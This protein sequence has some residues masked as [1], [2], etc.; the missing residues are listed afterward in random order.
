VPTIFSG[1][2]QGSFSEA[3]ILLEAHHTLISHTPES[4]IFFEIYGPGKAL[5]FPGFHYT[6]DGG[7]LTQFPLPYTAYLA[8]FYGIFGITGFVLANAI[9]LFVTTVTLSTIA[10]VFVD[11]R[12]TMIFL[13]LFIT[14]F[15]IG[16]FA[17]F[18][19]SENFASALLWSVVGLYF[20][21]RDRITPLTYYT[22]LITL[23]LLLFARIES[24]W[25]FA[26]MIVLI[27][28]EKKI[29]TFIGQAPWERLVLPV[30]T[31]F[32]IALTVAIMNQPFLFTIAKALLN[33]F[34][35]AND[36]T[37]MTLFDKLL[38][39]LNI[40][41]LYGLIGPLFITIAG[42]IWTLFHRSHRA[43]LLPI[44][45][46]LPFFI[47]YISPQITADHPWMLRRFVF[48]VLPATI[49]FSVIFLYHFAHKKIARTIVVYTLFVILLI[50][51]LPAFVKFVTYAENESLAD[52]VHFI[53]E[54]FS[55][56]DLILVDKDVAGNGWTMIT[57]PLRNIENIPAVY[58]FNPH[59][60]S[61]LNTESFETVYLITPYENRDRYMDV[62]GDQMHYVR[63]YALTVDH[64]ELVHDRSI[65]QKIPTHSTQVIRGIIYEIT[66]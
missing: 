20:M 14:S 28:R 26:I 19:L 64:L 61:S 22:F 39:Y 66:P 30:T 65:P 35:S 44:V 5:N 33:V 63:K 41:A 25:L 62:F 7:L 13:A 53:A 21:M 40:Y 16:W 45:I 49:L 4:D 52:Q 18:T 17:K 2:D 50:N 24:I 51:N 56:N 23:S 43:I 9:L 48:A 31:L 6:P 3:A 37:S 15:A 38:Y 27:L 12:G 47:Y 55:G 54:D 34:P 42:V 8:G 59:D 11:H 58:F 10:R 1:R 29:R 46:V 36:T 60:L 57:N 32:V